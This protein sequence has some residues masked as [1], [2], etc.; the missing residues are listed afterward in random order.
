MSIVQQFGAPARDGPTERLEGAANGAVGIVIHAL[1][2]P[3]VGSDAPDGSQSVFQ[4]T[5]MLDQPSGPHRGVLLDDD[6]SRRLA[7]TYGY[8]RSIYPNLD[9]GPAPRVPP[10]R[11]SA[12]LLLG[13]RA[14]SLAPRQTKRDVARILRHLQALEVCLMRVRRRNSGADWALTERLH[15]LSAEPTVGRDIGADSGEP[16]AIVVTETGWT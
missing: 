15:C 14:V 6:G 11:K 8:T 12:D 1:D 13:A 4:L 7:R 2:Y 5:K 10:L 16:A 3:P 9:A